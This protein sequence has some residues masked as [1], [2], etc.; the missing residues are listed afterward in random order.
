MINLNFEVGTAKLTDDSRVSLNAIAKE[1]LQ[2]PSVKIS[3][4]GHAS[5][6]GPKALNEQLSEQRARE[7]AKLLI[8]AGVDENRLSV[9]SYGISRPVAPN[10]SEENRR[11]NRRVEF[12][13]IE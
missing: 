10:D 1:L 7:V 13:V 2:H 12:D 6:E 11:L 4:S 9:S 5:S 3:I 8:Q